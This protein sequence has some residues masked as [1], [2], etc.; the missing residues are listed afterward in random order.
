MKRVAIVLALV[1]V[2]AM[3]VALVG[4]PA[5]EA[6]GTI[7]VVTKERGSGGPA[8]YACYTVE[9]LRDDGGGNGGVGGA[10]DDADGSADGTTTVNLL[11]PCSPC[12]V[13]QSLP[14]LP[15]DSPTPYLRE[16]SQVGAEGQTFT[17]EN[18][19]KPFLVVTARDLKTGKLVKG[20]CIAV[21]DL[22]QGGA[23]YAGC[24]GTL[25]NGHGDQDGKRNGKIKTTRLPN[26]GNFRVQVKTPF[27]TGYRNGPSVKLVA[28]PATTG[29]FEAV[30]IKLRRAR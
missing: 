8:R 1:A 3:P 21:V 26:T 23:D 27:P 17:F 7:T 30:T 13:S 25:V 18:F 14:D 6:A 15:D 22:D 5:A 19:L 24:D 11:G 2:L 12:R 20:A 4:P 29:E 28:E 10:C 9:D 16:P